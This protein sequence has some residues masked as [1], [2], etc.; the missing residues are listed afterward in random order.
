MLRAIILGVGT[1]QIN[2]LVCLLFS[3][4]RIA[5]LGGDLTLPTI[6]LTTVLNSIGNRL[7]A[8]IGVITEIDLP[9]RVELL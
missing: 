1:H 4:L 8:H 6:A 2:L 9:N 5:Q 7:L 3:G